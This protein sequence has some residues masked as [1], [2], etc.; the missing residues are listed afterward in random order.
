MTVQRYVWDVKMAGATARYV[1]LRPPKDAS[2][3]TVSSNEWKLDIAY[4]ENAITPRTKA[5][6]NILGRAV[7]ARGLTSTGPK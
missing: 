2:L 6:V 1:P 3:Q 5:L 4:L 7:S